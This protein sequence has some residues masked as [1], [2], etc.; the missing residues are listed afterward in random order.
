MGLYCRKLPLKSLAVA[1]NNAENYF[2]IV[3]YSVFPLLEEKSRPGQGVETPC[4]DNID[5][6]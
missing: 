5:T 2:W 1:F 6:M 4:R 3:L